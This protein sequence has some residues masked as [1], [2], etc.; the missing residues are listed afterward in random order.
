MQK[1]E[2]KSTQP[3][4]HKYKV[5]GDKSDIAPNLLNQKFTLERP[6]NVW[7]SNITTMWTG[8]KW[9]Y[10]TVV[11]DLYAKKMIGWANSNAN[12]PDSQPSWDNTPTGRFFRH[13][14]TKWVPKKFYNSYDKTKTSLQK[15]ICQ[16]NNIVKKHHYNHYNHY[17]LPD[18]AGRLIFSNYHQ[19][20]CSPG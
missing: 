7:C 10:L 9:L 19:P 2:I 17:L 15:Y 13:F 3:Q 16:H 8:A 11:I 18:A 12:R 14:R 20:V 4:K 1:A 5:A 6:N